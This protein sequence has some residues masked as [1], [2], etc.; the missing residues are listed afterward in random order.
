MTRPG[1]EPGFGEHSTKKIIYMYKLSSY[2]EAIIRCQVWLWYLSLSLSLSIYI[3]I[4]IYI[5]IR[6]EQFPI[7]FSAKLLYFMVRIFTERHFSNDPN[8]RYNE[9][10][11]DILIRI[12]IK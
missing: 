10:S 8:A 1:I 4:Y 2:N 9:E 12:F 6:I 5:Y 3:Y 7:L 11:Y